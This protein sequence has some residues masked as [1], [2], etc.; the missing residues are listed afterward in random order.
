MVGN[1][2]WLMSLWEAQIRTQK[3]P[4]RIISMWTHSKCS[5]RI[6]TLWTHSKKTVI[7]KPR[8]DASE[9]IKPAY[10]LISDFWFSNCQKILLLKLSSL[11]RFVME[12]LENLYYSTTNTDQIHLW[13]LARQV[14]EQAKN[15]HQLVTSPTVSLWEYKMVRLKNGSCSGSVSPCNQKREKQHV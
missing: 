11:W 15:N 4:H 9:E 10:T 8:K 12:A 2:I 14:Q 6:I 3:Y 13:I 1:K 7:C 5:H